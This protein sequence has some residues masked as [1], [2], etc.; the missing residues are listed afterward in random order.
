MK[1]EERYLVICHVGWRVGT[2][3]QIAIWIAE[4]LPLSL[5][6]EHVFTI[7]RHKDVTYFNELIE[8][9]EVHVVTA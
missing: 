5:T 7:A 2:I 3:Q 4:K 6:K 8:T 9:S 1:T